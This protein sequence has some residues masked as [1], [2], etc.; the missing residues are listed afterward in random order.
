MSQERTKIL[1]FPPIHSV[2]EWKNKLATESGRSE[3]ILSYLPLVKFI[4]RKI[5]KRTPPNI[6]FDDLVSCG[7][8]G[9]MDAL[10]KFD[11]EREILFKTYAEHRIRG[12]ILDEL[13]KLD[14]VP[15]SVRNQEKED[16]R[17]ERMHGN[18]SQNACTAKQQV[19]APKTSQSIRY[20]DDYRKS[21]KKMFEGTTEHCPQQ[22]ALESNSKQCLQ[23][24]IKQLSHAEST[25]VE[26]YYFQDK[27]IKDIGKELG[28]S[29]SRVSQ[30][31]MRA[32]T[33]LEEK[34]LYFYEDFLSAVA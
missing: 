9:L 22:I 2:Q 7:V 34:L 18:K 12:N 6:E 17:N 19:N 28:V 26:L 25:V 1:Q 30:L 10:M 29:A 13:R 3:L 21:C 8:I 20:L 14:L 11:P 4:A 5:Y 27:N 32:K 24:T 33:K 23:S 31:H 15:R 16:L